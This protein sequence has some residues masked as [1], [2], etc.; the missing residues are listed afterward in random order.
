MN[1][2]IASDCVP[3]RLGIGQGTIDSPIIFL[4]NLYIND[5]VRML[6]DLSIS[7]CMQMIVYR[8]LVITGIKCIIVYKQA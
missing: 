2:A 1:R 8:L 4:F 7:I 3:V 5:V 6:P